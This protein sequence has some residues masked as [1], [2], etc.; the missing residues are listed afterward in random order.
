MKEK[1]PKYRQIIDAAV[2]VIAENGYHAA[3][4]SKI[5]KQAKVA[6][7]TIYL[8]FKNKEDILISLFREKISGHLEQ[9]KSELNRKPTASEKL[10]ALIH[11]HFQMLV[12]DPHLAVVLQ[13]ELRQVNK[14][15]RKQINEILKDY[16]KVID[17]V[18]EF[19]KSTGEFRKDL[20][21]RI[22][23]QMIFGAI[24]ETATTW[25]M[26]EQKYDLLSNAEKIFDLLTNGFHSPKTNRHTT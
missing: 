26:K 13:L 18:I 22:A 5:A 15:L 24:D 6:D 17:E 14:E 12:E 20:D 7:G 11:R 16:L 9:V 2:I 21:V 4:V 23:R 19:G 10:F 25:V 1:R 3:Q 8:Y